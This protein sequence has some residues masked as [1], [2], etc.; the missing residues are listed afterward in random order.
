M[1][2][3]TVALD[4]GP[5]HGHRTGVGHRRRRTWPT[6]LR[7]RPDVALIPYVLS[8]R[9]GQRR[10]AA[11]LPLPAALAHGC[12]RACDRPRV[13]RW[14][15]RRRRRPR[16]ELRRA[17]EPAPDGRVGVR[18]LVPRQP[19][20]RRAP[21]RA[22]RRRGA[23]RAPSAAGA[24]VHASRE[25]TAD[26]VRELLGT[27]RVEVVHLGPL[28]RRRPPTPRR[29]RPRIDGRPFV[30]AVGTLERRKNLPRSST[31]SATSPTSSPTSAS[32]SP[33]RP[34][35]TAAAVDRRDRRAARRASGRRVICPGR[36]DDD[37]EG[38]AAQPRVGARLPVARRGLRLPAARGEAPACPIVATPGRVDPRG[39][40][41]R[42]SSWSTGDDPAVFAGRHRT[43]RRR[44]RPAARADR[45]RA[46]ATSRRFS[47]EAHRRRMA[48]LYRRAI[49]GGT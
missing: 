11:R 24:V 27:D 13:D 39:G 21:R 18:L 41:R 44:R 20:S 1:D 10:P 34:A 19:A 33:A 16:H 42:A 49:D 4:V 38:V 31:R 45:G 7:H 12:G 2:P 14:L 25:A 6:A 46:R 32:S 26:V 5:L 35:T 30:L 3:V 22:P 17:A 47:W 29:P 8:F 15:G 36:V 48:A 23:A 40:R 43:R 9:A 28:P 37:A